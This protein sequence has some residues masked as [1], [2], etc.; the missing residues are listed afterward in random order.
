MLFGEDLAG[1]TRTNPP[2]NTN[3]VDISV[4]AVAIGH[5]RTWGYPDGSPTDHYRIPTYQ[6]KVSAKISGKLISKDFEAIR[7]GVQQKGSIGPRV[8]GLAD[9]QTHIIK[10]WIPTYSVHSARSTERG[11]G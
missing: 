7:F 9:Q 3:R 5:A 4:G 1:R 11:V 2:E 10:S 6:V 8:V